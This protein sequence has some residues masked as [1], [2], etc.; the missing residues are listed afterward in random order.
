MTSSISV[1]RRGGSLAIPSL[2]EV[3]NALK[4]I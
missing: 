3:Q 1:T 4:A 2:D